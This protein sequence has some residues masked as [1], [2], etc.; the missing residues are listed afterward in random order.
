VTNDDTILR[1]V[2]QALAED[3]A[4]QSIRKNLPAI[5]GAGLIVVV[6]VGGWQL[7]SAQRTAA[8]TKASAAYDE[9]LR[10]AGGEEATKT[11]ETLADGS[12]GYAALAKMRLAGDHSAK[13]E[14]DK[15]LALYRDVYAG[16]GSKRLKDMAR[17][18]AAFLSLADSRDA[19]LTDIGALETDE[20]AI[21]FHA[22]EILALAALKA[23]DYQ[24]AEEM[25][26]KAAASPDAPEGVRLRAAE[27][28]A[29]ASAGKAGVVIPAIA[30]SKKSEVD[31]FLETLEAAGS[32]LSS[33]VAGDA[34][35]PPA[36]AAPEPL[37]D[38]AAPEGN[39]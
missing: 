15:A 2:D 9:A 19:V 13:G 11:L 14:R 8:A 12:G 33:V 18:K 36:D 22:R 29:L 39:E 30:E 1:E 7:W 34:A 4:S 25:F 23:G 3:T 6:G 16:G 5:V 21:G 24:S 37:G 28:M 32:D 27:F 26:R 10:N 38:E 20:T 35:E 31:Q 17:I